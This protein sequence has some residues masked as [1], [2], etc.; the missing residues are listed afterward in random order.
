[1]GRWLLWWPFGLDAQ[2]EKYGGGEFVKL[3]AQPIEYIR[4]QCR[5]GTDAYEELLRVV[6]DDIGDDNTVMSID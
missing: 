3:L 4:R 1:L 5:T 6:I 2:W